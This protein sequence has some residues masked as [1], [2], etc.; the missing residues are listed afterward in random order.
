MKK[1]TSLKETCLL[2]LLLCFV[3]ILLLVTKS[4]YIE[5][6]KQELIE[7]ITTMLEQNESQEEEQIDKKQELKIGDEIGLIVIPSID[8]KATIVEGTTQEILKYAV[9]HFENTEIW[10]GNVALASHNR[11][12]YAHYFS[13]INEL[14]NGEEIIYITSM[15]ERR[16]RVTENVIIS[17][18]NV[19][20]L[21]NTEDNTITLIT[22]VTG[23]KDKR[24][25]IKG[26]KIN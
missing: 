24:Q 22:C 4:I 17:E 12:S 13:R 2:V 8:L 18:T 1:I 23:R 5:N 19:E 9:G 16:Y 3:I 6:K 25:C 26:K 14:K 20:V 7:N 15:G 11:G 21:E 10:D